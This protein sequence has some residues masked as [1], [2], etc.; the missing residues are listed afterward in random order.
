MQNS[1]ALVNLANALL[2]DWASGILVAALISAVLST[3]ATTL[4]TASMILSE[5]FR[6]DIN[7][8][9]SFQQTKLFIILIG[10]LSMI[11]SLKITSIVS[12]LLLALSFYSGAFIIPLAA[13]LFNLPYH[14]RFSIAAMISGGTLALTGKLLITYKHAEIGQMLLISGFLL[15]AILIFLPSLGNRKSEI[16]NVENN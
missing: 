15:N 2:P 8:K 7:N 12:A 10:V 1:S 11:I 4:L 3:A 14:K 9:Q 5:L 16:K 6:K 13:A